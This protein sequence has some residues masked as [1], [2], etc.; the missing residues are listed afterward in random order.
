MLKAQNVIKYFILFLT[1]IYSSCN[2]QSTTING[3]YS[4]LSPF[5]EHFDYYKFD[6]QGNFEY[7]VGASLGF[8]YYGK[9]TYLIKDN[10]L[11][12]DF[13]KTKLKGFS[14]YYRYNYWVNNNNTV[15]F[16]F[17]IFDLKGNEIPF[18]NIYILKLKTGKLTNNKGFS[19]LTIDKKYVKEKYKIGISLIGYEPQNIT[20]DNNL[21]YNFKVYLKKSDN[22]SF[23]K[24]IYNQKDTL[25]I[26]DLNENSMKI[27]DKNG[28][29][30]IWKK[31]SK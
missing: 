17:N 1:V 4:N 2:A 9:G 5:Q 8:D 21:N 26:L 7:G 3:F 24:P 31:I 27:R 19:E 30:T 20:V 13:K 10:Q 22:K 29:I 11:I 18:V 6:K 28:K 16:K 25:G 14:G 23:G 15:K 12:L